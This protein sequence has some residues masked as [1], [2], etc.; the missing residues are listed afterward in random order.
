LPPE[1]DDGGDRSP[2]RVV[3]SA[4]EFEDAIAS[5][6]ASENPQNN[7]E[8]NVAP[9]ACEHETSLRNTRSITFE[10]ELRTL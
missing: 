10:I 5:L 4:E 1:S 3:P 8:Q 6:P 2:N 9:L 7:L